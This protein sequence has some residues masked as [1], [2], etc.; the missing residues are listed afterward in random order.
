MDAKVLRYVAD[1]IDAVDAV[2]RSTPDGNFGNGAIP[3][4]WYNEVIGEIRD[5]VGPGDC[6]NFYPKVGEV[7]S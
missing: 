4:Y 7:Q 3:I 5:E 1:L 6:H 2:N